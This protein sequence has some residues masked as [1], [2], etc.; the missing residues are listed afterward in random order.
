MEPVENDLDL[1]SQSEDE[2]I[3]E[4]IDVVWM[5]LLSR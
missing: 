2:F 3:L 4:S 1:I 5:S